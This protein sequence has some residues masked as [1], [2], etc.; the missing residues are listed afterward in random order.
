MEQPARQQDDWE[1]DQDRI[2]R[3]VCAY[4]RLDWLLAL[5]VALTTWTA[6]T[7]FASPVLHPGFWADVAVASGARPPDSA[8]SGLGIGLARAVFAHFGV[9]RGISLLMQLG[10]VA[11]ALLVGLSYLLMRGL[12]SA[13]LSV[14]PEELLTLATRLRWLVVVGTLAFACSE[15]LWLR[16]QFLSD[17]LLCLLLG[18]VA[19]TAFDRFR[20]H[21]NLGWH[22]LCSLATGLLAAE[23]PIGLL[24][25]ALIHLWDRRERKL[26][27]ARR[28]ALK[29][30]VQDLN[31]PGAAT[32]E[33]QA[34]AVVSFNA[35]KA[36]DPM[37]F[38]DDE[39][40]DEVKKMAFRQEAWLAGLMFVTGF[41]VALTIGG[42]TFCGL[43][44]LAVND[45]TLWNY[46]LML[47][48]AWYRQ[49]R[50][51]MN[52]FGLLFAS[53][54]SL[55]PFGVV[56]VLVSQ[57]TDAEYKFSVVTSLL[58]LLMGVVAWLQLSPFAGCWYWTW[59]LQG[60]GTASESLRAVM[61]FFGAAAL[62][63]A[64]Q[65]AC[66]AVRR[67]VQGARKIMV[68]EG[69]ALARIR[70][71]CRWLLAAVAVAV[72]VLS[73]NGRRQ[74][75]VLRKLGLVGEYVKTFAEQV[76]G[77]GWIFTD[78][79]FDDALLIELRAQGFD[80]PRPLSMMSGRTGY[81][82]YL[83]TRAATDDEDRRVLKV[84][85]LETLRF[86]AAERKDRLARMAMQLGFEVLVKCRVTGA[87]SAGL[88]L[89]VG[90]PEDDAAF[91]RA[92]AAARELG[93]KA[94]AIAD[95]ALSDSFDREVADKFDFIL[96]R[97][98]RM[99]E[100][101][102]KQ[103]LLKEDGPSAARERELAN[104]LDA[105]N[106]PYRLLKSKLERKGKD[107]NLVLSPQEGLS[108]ALKR[109][110]F[111]L[112]RPYANRMLRLDP[113]DANAN[114]AVGMWAIENHLYGIALTY[115]ESALSKRPE[116]PSILNNLAMVR[117]KLGDLEEARKLIERAAK[118]NPKSPE[119]QKNL[120]R[121]RQAAPRAL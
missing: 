6:L 8:A 78:G 32:Q 73:V 41:V 43:G 105:A 70:R 12:F 91:D 42:R 93:E 45:S 21:R 69:V 114:F 47:L 110:D 14:K 115:L 35:G 27:W 107:E 67:Q 36:D 98:A 101:R 66:C 103:Y 33:G 95:D 37:A 26:Y 34:D 31:D 72:V 44:G 20:R 16:M 111:N 90:T 23:T 39:L 22:C 24:L 96:W 7:L 13:R 76:R 87:R 104:R 25:A 58:I 112:A 30:L 64:L 108:I 60:V 4:D 120:K 50:V 77:L 2:R 106:G 113:D 18:V 116:E 62:A 61:A 94:L 28:G 84:G 63:G 109:G 80:E 74:T 3:F 99:A 10:H 53:A 9:E 79:A 52:P 71:S 57:S 59:D 56:Y 49:M 121:I 1:A 38:F 85:A 46:P 54:F 97:L 102:M 119:I 81:A 40:E 5:L 11:G 88:M 89:R 19:I 48:T 55:F 75:D 118:A 65:V 51:M 29:V 86:W 100:L 117:F 82:T 83:R 68:E 17:E 92:D 15:A